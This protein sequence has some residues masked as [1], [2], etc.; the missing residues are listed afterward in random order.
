MI[1]SLQRMESC[2]GMMRFQFILIYAIFFLGM[3]PDYT[4]LP[5]EYYGTGKGRLYDRKAALHDTE[6][7]RPEPPLVCQPPRLVTLW[8]EMDATSQIS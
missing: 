4:D 2:H 6:L 7:P 1:G 3:K 8:S 5:S